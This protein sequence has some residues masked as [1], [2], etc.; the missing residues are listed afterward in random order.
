MIRRSR[1]KTNQPRY[2]ATGEPIPFEISLESVSK[3]LGDPARWR[4]LLELAKNEPM[5]VNELARRIGKSADMT[6]KHLGTLHAKGLVVARFGRI[7][8][9]APAIMPAP[10]ATHINL[11]PCLLELG[12]RPLS[13]TERR[14]PL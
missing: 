7:Y 13:E 9:L 10:G 5:P 1:R 4:L 2:T 3:I 8:Q 6:S 14:G 11:G 12:P